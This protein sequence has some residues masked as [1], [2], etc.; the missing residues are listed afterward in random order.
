MSPRT[1]TSTSS[2]SRTT[3]RVRGHNLFRGRCSSGG[4][5]GAAP[6]CRRNGRS[7]RDAPAAA[8]GGSTG[9]RPPAK[10]AP[11]SALK[12]LPITTIATNSMTGR[13]KHRHKASRTDQRVTNTSIVRRLNCHGTARSLSQVP[14]GASAGWKS[15]SSVPSFQSSAV[16]TG[17]ERFLNQLGT[18]GTTPH[19]SDDSLRALAFLRTRPAE[20]H[21][22]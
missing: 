20:P 15:G 19:R 9:D 13:P 7:G 11:T 18:S 10:A 5:E 6:C 16:P 22:F 1:P 3:E 2:T 14:S 4:R 12:T 8:S 21:A 17:F